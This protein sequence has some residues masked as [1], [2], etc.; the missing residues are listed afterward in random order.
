MKTFVWQQNITN[1]NGL[2]HFYLSDLLNTLGH[3]DAEQI[4]FPTDIPRKFYITKI[5]IKKGGAIQSKYGAFSVTIDKRGISYATGLPP[6]HQQNSDFHLDYR[7]GILLDGNAEAT[8]DFEL[9]PYP[10]LDRDAGDKLWFQ[11]DNTEPGTYSVVISYISAETSAEN[12]ED[13]VLFWQVQVPDNHPRTWLSDSPN[14]HEEIVFSPETPRKFS[15]TRILLRKEGAIQ[16]GQLRAS[17]DKGGVPCSSTLA[18]S[19]QLG[20]LSAGSLETENK[21]K[22]GPYLTVDRDAGDKLR[23]QIDTTEG[24]IYTVFLYYTGEDAP[25]SGWK[26]IFD[27]RPGLPLGGTIETDGAGW[28]GYTLLV[29]IDPAVLGYSKMSPNKLR[30]TLEAGQNGGWSPSKAFIGPRIVGTI[31][32]SSMRPLSFGGS[33][34]T[35]MTAG[36]RSVSDDASVTGF[37]MSNGLIMK[38]YTPTGSPG[39]LR[40]LYTQPGT[41]VWWKAGDDANNPKSENYRTYTTQPRWCGS[42]ICGETESFKIEGLRRIEAFF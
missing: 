22:L 40:G 5:Q 35:S 26:R 21:W 25:A 4:I 9:G 2:P 34:G 42:Y 15:V 39:T 29:A 24:G 17:I 32:A 20:T 41:K 38:I 14:S 1:D 30:A 6:F 23:Y 7:L 33:S 10:L 31:N 16:Q 8:H 3:P 13:K 36:A 11:Q 28:G 12:K 27:W 19:C 37:D 18:P